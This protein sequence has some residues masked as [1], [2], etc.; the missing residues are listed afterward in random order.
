[1]DAATT[2]LLTGKDVAE[3]LSL[4]DCIQAVEGHSGCMEK[5]AHLLQL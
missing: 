4:S 2:L 1:M 3:L 5:G